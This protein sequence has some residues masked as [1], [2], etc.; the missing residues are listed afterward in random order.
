MDTLG[1][2]EAWLEMQ[3]KNY[4]LHKYVHIYANHFKGTGR[5]FIFFPLDVNK[6][7]II[8]LRF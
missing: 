6:P 4:F 1:K 7:L 2:Q 3:R 8:Q 5:L